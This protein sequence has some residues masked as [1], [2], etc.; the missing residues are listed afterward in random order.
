LMQPKIIDSYGGPLLMLERQLLP[1]WG[2][3]DNIGGVSPER[4]DR[5]PLTDYQRAC[6]I[7][8]FIAPLEVLT[9]SGVVFSGDDLGLGLERELCGILRC[10]NI[11]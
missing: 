5:E 7:R 8:E 6:N 10:A 3:I 1:Y 2:G 11:L 9:E 4:V